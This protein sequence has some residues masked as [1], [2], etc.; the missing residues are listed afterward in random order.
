MGNRPA[1]RHRSGKALRKPAAPFRAR[2]VIMAKVPIAGRVKTRLARR[3]GV[4]EAVRF[5]RATACAVLGR[6]SRQPFWET[7]IAVAPDT[8]VGARVWPRGVTL[9]RQ[10]RGDIGVRMQRPMRLLPPGPVCVVGTDVPGI[11]VEHIR[12]AFRLIGSRDAVFGPAG[13]GGFWLVGLRRRPRVLDPYAGGV[14]WSHTETLADVRRNLA[15]HPIG[16]TQC[17]HDVD[18]PEDLARQQGAYG[19]RIRPHLR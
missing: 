1:K 16:L 17:L 3:I 15:G 19:R 9:L 10:G 5:Y 11:E 4:A 2:L 13:D 18:E 14:R 6:L 7:I 8:G 12:R